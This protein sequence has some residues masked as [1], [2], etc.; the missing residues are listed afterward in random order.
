MGFE[1]VNSHFL[2]VRSKAD[3]IAAFP[4]HQV[5]LADLADLA[6]DGK[7][8][9]ETFLGSAWEETLGRYAFN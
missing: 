9:S 2:R 3:A 7:V 1:P 4:D 8:T 6:R 5:D